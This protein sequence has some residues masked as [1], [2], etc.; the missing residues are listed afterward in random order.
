VPEE[1]DD[2]HNCTENVRRFEKLVSESPASKLAIV[3]DSVLC[4]PLPYS[5]VGHEGKPCL[6]NQGDDTG[7]VEQ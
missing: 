2:E 7:P 5:A 4:S 6:G 3:N 1:C